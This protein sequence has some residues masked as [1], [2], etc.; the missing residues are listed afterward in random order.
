M[1][2]AGGVVL[3]AGVLADR[4]LRVLFAGQTMNMIGNTAMIIVLGIWVK[5]LTGSSG[6][7]GLVFL[8]PAA[9]ALVAPAAGLVVDRFPRRRLLV[10]NDS[11]TGLVVGLLL[12]VHH[13]DQVWL[14]YLVAGVYGI[15]GI[16]YRAARGGLLHSMVPDQRLGE[17]NGLFAS[18]SQGMRIVGPLAG[19]AIYAAWGGG[20]V[21][22]ADMGTFA[23][24]VAS[25]L[26]LRRFGDLKR[27][28]RG[29]LVRTSGAFFPELTSGVRHL[30]GDGVIRR[31]VI[32]STVGF[33]G[34]GMIDVAMF[35][36]VDQGLGRPTSWI[37][38]LTSVQ[39][40]GS[41]LAGLFVGPA[42]RR[43]GEYSVACAGFLLN[44]AGLAAASTATLAGALTGSALIG[45]GLPMVLVA[46]LTVLQRRTPAGLQGRVVAASDA[47][48]NTPFSIAIAVGA[49]LI[50]T[51]GFRPIYIGVAG[52]FTVAGLALLPHLK[53]TKPTDTGRQAG[54]AREGKP[55]EV[56]VAGKAQE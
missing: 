55:A 37:G 13:S 28:G 4:N 53:S 34:A 51:V 11:V 49:E 22:V 42:M 32:A 5:D 24:S 6:A 45:I 7:A 48:I 26:A 21:A 8:L 41:V 35:S 25:Y 50:A 38:V 56:A 10:V 12:L 52:G 54:R 16:V 2:R 19:A 1:D 46:E 14:I 30:F 29:R 17:V 44:G 33:A 23:V 20:V 18:L 27:A 3:K 9:A 31:L 15:S 39:G 36:L 43:T 47:I 40:A